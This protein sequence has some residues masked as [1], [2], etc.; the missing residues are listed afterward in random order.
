MSFEHFVSNVSARL[1]ETNLQQKFAVDE[2]QQINEYKHL[3][4]KVKTLS[5]YLELCHFFTQCEESTFG[6]DVHSLIYRGVANLTWKLE[7]SIERLTH[8]RTDTEASIVKEFMAMRPEAFVHIES[9]FERLAKMQHYGLPTRLLDFTTNPLVALFFACSKENESDFEFNND[10]RIMISSANILSHDSPFLTSILEFPY[11]MV[12]EDQT[13]S[14]ILGKYK[15]SSID[16]LN[17]YNCTRGPLQLYAKPPYSNQRIINQGG[18]FLVFPNPIDFELNY[19]SE[20]HYEGIG[21]AFFSKNL[22]KI[23]N[24]ILTSQFISIIVQKIDKKEILK[25]LMNVGITIDFIYPELEY[26]AKRIANKYR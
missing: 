18:L 5:E 11:S 15:V 12:G 22:L 17:S 24:S 1:P 16:Y 3:T 20:D 25:E 23:N 10:G 9:S 4:F 2:S 8:K 19:N 26:T 13:S 14:N 21:E 6:E 7:P